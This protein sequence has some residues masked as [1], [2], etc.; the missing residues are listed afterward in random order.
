[1]KTATESSA[2]ISLIE[3]ADAQGSVAEVYQEMMDAWQ[4][5]PNPMKIYATNPELLSNRWKGFQHAAEHPTIDARLQTAIRMCV[6]AQHDCDY[7]VGLNEY[8]LVNMFELEANAVST[9]KANP[10]QAPFPENETAL[11][12]FVIKVVTAPKSTNKSDIV[13]LHDLGWSDAEIVFASQ[14]AADM[15][16]TDIMINAFNIP[17]DY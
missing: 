17:T 15:V 14:Y 13:T 6:S 10:S 2:L 16:A 9:M 1:M 12:A 4:M 7:C 3:P 11:L 8:M 5:V